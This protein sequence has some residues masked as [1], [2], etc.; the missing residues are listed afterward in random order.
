MKLLLSILF[1]S[2]S[3]NTLSQ[4]SNR[5]GNIEFS[6]F[7]IYNKQAEYS[8]QFGDVSY[9]N[10]LKLYGS[11]FGIKL[12]YKKLL[13]D[14]TFIKVGG[15]YL[16]FGINKIQNKTV[17]SNLLIK[18]TA[19]P[20]KYPSPVFILYSTSKYHYHNL[21]YYLGLQKEFS[22]SSCVFFISLDYFHAYKISQK[23]FIPGIDNYY[24]TNYKGSFGDFFNVDFGLK[25]Y[26]L[27]KLSF[28][29]ALIL[30]IY[31]SCQLD[32][33]FKEN[34]SSRINN[35][36]NGIGISINFHLTN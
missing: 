29:P 12:D 4:I 11:D 34:P 3:L 7:H 21:F 25:K 32:T 13:S 10:N 20:I 36:L 16:D 15:G 5:K 35:W 23:Y 19:R 8:S 6:F 22:I 30:P 1:L 14:N 24:K 9:K 26:H 17:N 33:N 27:E 28:E 31:K 18:S 2:I